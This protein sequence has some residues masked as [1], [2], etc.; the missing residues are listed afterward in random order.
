MTMPPSTSIPPSG[1]SGSSLRLS[2]VITIL[3]K[4]FKEVFRDR[5]TV[6][7]VIISP[8]VIT[9][10]LFAVLGLVI[11]SQTMKEKSRVYEIGVVGGESSP[12]LN[13]AIGEIAQLHAR[14][15]RA[16]E[17]E[18]E[19]VSKRLAAVVKVPQ[20]AERLTAEYTPVPIEIMMDAGD[21]SS[22]AA[23]ARLSGG[24][25]KIGDHVISARLSE[26]HLSA[27]FATPFDVTESPIKR[28]GNVASLVL[29]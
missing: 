12:R 29:A 8:L 10:A 16:S 3:R 25:N 19:I 24:F 28:G 17:A 21:E 18:S 11:G 4:E 14:S 22:Q 5:R 20:N 27:D 7:S 23:A 26:K 15:V 13:K 2:R 1:S 6:I 9:P